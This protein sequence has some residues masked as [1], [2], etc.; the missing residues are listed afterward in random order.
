MLASAMGFVENHQAIALIFA[1]IMA[2]S[3]V[4]SFQSCGVIAQFRAKVHCVYLFVISIISF[5]S[6]I[7][8][9]IAF[10]CSLTF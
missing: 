4:L 3:G 10:L 9:F 1:A 6:S 7:I 8:L 5:M 2:L